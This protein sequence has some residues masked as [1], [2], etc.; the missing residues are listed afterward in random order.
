MPL[1]FS[2]ITTKGSF[3]MVYTPPPP[4]EPTSYLWLWGSGSD[5]RL[6]LGNT[7]SY[8][9]PKQIGSLGSWL[10]IAAGYNHGMALKTDGT[11]W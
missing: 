1:I 7:T 4:P 8:S 6:G 9:S 5:G 11:L 10:N 2:G 3:E